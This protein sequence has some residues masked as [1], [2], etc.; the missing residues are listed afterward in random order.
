MEI[1][2]IRGISLIIYFDSTAT[3]KNLLSITL[4]IMR[5]IDK[6]APPSEPTWKLNLN[7]P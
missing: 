2:K 6:C 7:S 3:G 5:T 1:L 4:I